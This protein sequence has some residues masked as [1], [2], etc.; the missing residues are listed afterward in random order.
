[1]CGRYTVTVTLEELMFR[2]MAEGT[3]IPYHRPR[4]NVAP[5]QMVPAIISDGERNRI[6]EL[7]WGLVPSWAEDDKSGFKMINA[8][9][10]TLTDKPSFRGLL[11]RKR[12]L[13]P[14][15]GYY[16]WKAGGTRKQPMRITLRDEGLFAMAGLYDTW[17][18]ADGRKVSTC[19]IITTTANALT[20]DIHERMPV[21]LR[22]EDEMR[23]LDRSKHGAQLLP[24]L[25]P[26]P[27]SEMRVYPVSPMVGSVK[28]DDASLIDEHSLPPEPS[29]GTLF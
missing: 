1:M 7:R 17:V 8:R 10:E 26:Y 20:V 9:K 5:A 13:I 24:L 14:A 15:D 2:F 11:E 18:D 4:Y 19:T 21:I 27:A 16:E 23:W 28:V 29:Q 25:A 22:R 6:G 12:C 3:N